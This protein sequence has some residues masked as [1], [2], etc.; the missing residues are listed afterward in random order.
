MIE[1][2]KPRLPLRIRVA[3]KVL[4]HIPS[5][6]RFRLDDDEPP[7]QLTPMEKS[8]Q[9]AALSVLQ[10]Y[11][12]GEMDYADAPPADRD[13]QDADLSGSRSAPSS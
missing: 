9:D 6:A 3:F 2:N 7:R 5:S 11:L 8:T 13:A 12:L 1:K 10:Q 4:E